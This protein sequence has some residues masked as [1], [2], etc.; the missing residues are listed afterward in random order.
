MALLNMQVQCYNTDNERGYIMELNEFIDV[1]INLSE[2]ARSQIANFLRECGR[3]SDSREKD[4]DTVHTVQ[5]L[6]P[7]V[8]IGA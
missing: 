4:D 7:S 8:R 1:Y 2:D 3:Q 6:L 5:S